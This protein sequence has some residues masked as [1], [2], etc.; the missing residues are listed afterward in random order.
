V[1]TPE[2]EYLRAL[3]GIRTLVTARVTQP[4]P[5]TIA[6]AVKGDS[7]NT[8]EPSPLCERQGHTAARNMLGRRERFD[9]VPFF[10]TE[11][12]D[13]SLAY[14]GHAE[15]FDEA[16]LEGQLND[17]AHDCTITFRRGGKKL[18]VALVRQDLAGLQ[19]ELDVEMTMGGKPRE[20][21]SQGR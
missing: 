18:A 4:S 17:D 14:V 7:E 3:G 5:A 6:V 9:A 13:F 11:Q 1:L 2:G 12:Y 20:E 10:W 21:N 16:K 19:A 8:R 15:R